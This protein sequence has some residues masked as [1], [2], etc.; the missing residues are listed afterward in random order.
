MKILLFD[1]R[2]YQIKLY[3]FYSIFEHRNFFLYLFMYLFILFCYYYFILFAIII[4]I[5]LFTYYLLIIIYFIFLFWDKLTWMLFLQVHTF[6]RRCN[7]HAAC[8][9]AVAI[10]SGDDVIVIDSC[11][12]RRTSNR[13][14]GTVAIRMI[15]NGELTPHTRILRI[16][17]GKGYKVGGK[18]DK[19]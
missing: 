10:R 11:G 8:H 6:Q 1:V 16:N 7:R 12:A 13:R 19:I 14:P 4:F 17:N 2:I 3:K 5:I 18:L 15:L 9:C